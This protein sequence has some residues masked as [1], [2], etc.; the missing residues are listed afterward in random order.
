MSRFFVA[1]LTSFFLVIFQWFLWRLQHVMEANTNEYEI[2]H[3]FGK[4]LVVSFAWLSF[5]L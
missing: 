5:Q 4:C 2:T 3:S 1:V